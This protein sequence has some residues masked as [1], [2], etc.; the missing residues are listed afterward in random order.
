MP[1]KR[2]LFFLSLLLIESVFG[3]SEPISAVSGLVTRILGASEL[4]K[5]QF[6]VIPSDPGTSLDVF[7]LDGSNGK[8]VVRGNNGVSLATGLNNYLKYTLNV[9]ISWGRNNSGVLAVLPSE[10]PV[11]AASR[12]VMPMKWRYS[13]NVCTPGYSLVWY[14]FEQWQFFIDWMALNGVNLP[15]AFNGQEAVF[16]ATFSAFGLTD[17]EI[18]AY[19]SG[20]A[21]LP[22]NRM[23]N[24]QAWGALNSQVKGLD[25]GW[26]TSQYNLQLRIVAAMRAYGMTPVL[27]GFAGHVPAGLQR[28][29]PNASYTHS[30]DWCGFNATYGSVALLEPSDPVYV[31]VGT[32]INKAILAAF[33]DPTGQEIPH[34]NADTFNEMEPNNSSL[35][36]LA[37]CNAN[38]YASMTA[39]D[40]RAVYVMQGW[41]FLEG[42]W[43]FDRTKAFLGSVPIGGMLI[44]DLFSDGQ[45]QWNKYDGYFGH[46]WIWNS[47]IV[48]GGRRGIY[49]TLPSYATSPY[50]DRAKSPNLIGIGVTPE[51]IDMSQPMFDVTLEAGWRSVGPDPLAW[52]QSYAVRRYGGESPAMVA[53][54]D[55]L[56]LSAYNNRDIDESIIEDM[57]GS[58]SGSR[59]TNATGFVEALRLYVAAFS[60]SMSL[61]PTTGPASYDITDLTRQVLC[62][63]FQDLH[64]LFLSRL[65]APRGQSSPPVSRVSPTLPE[66]QSLASALLGV[67]GDVDT[68]DGADVNFLL[69]TWLE[70]AAGWGFNESQVENRVFNARNQITLWGPNGEINDYAAKIGWAGLVSDY[71]LPRWQKHTGNTLACWVNATSPD[72]QDWDSWGRDMLKWEQAWSLN[73][74]ARYPTEPSGVVP[75]D[76]AQAM[77]AK[78]AGGKGGGGVNPPPGK[79]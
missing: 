46:Y 60:G 45:P 47:L 17:E 44:L 33:G 59:N 7:E 76:N 55:T 30:S 15:L 3:G 48:F 20:P 24:M 62:N 40:P 16:A 63:L 37:A 77:L 35:D 31:T 56:F 73:T 50:D 78:Y 52:L 39:A 21:F 67:I 5:F 32:A 19:F 72:C 79:R 1:Y 8:V 69:G 66:L 36:Y 49:G 4:G 74:S 34:F 38:M 6:E 64:S 65:G 14:S 23:G 29:F 41:L 42:F 53:A 71:Y 58:A 2:I 43:T 27:P 10:L 54:M 28:V 26:M 75:L 68:T 12:T 9:S 13:L 70:D 22:W 61:D 25:W 11:P 51:A 57:P 18:W